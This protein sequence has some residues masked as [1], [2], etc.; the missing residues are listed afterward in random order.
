MGMSDDPDAAPDYWS[1]CDGPGCSEKVGPDAMADQSHGA[2]FCSGVCYDK[3]ENKL[4]NT[5]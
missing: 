3:W 4:N 1:V 2:K 5:Y